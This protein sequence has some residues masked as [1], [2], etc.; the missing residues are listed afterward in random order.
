MYRKHWIA[1]MFA[2]LWA[3]ATPQPSSTSEVTVSAMK[4]VRPVTPQPTSALIAGE[5]LALAYS[6]FR[7]GQHPDRG[8][9]DASPTAAQVEEDLR[10]L[11]DHGVKLIRL[12]DS[13][14][15]SAMV[16]DVIERTKLPI[17]VVLG[18]WLHAE[19][20]AH[21]TCAWLTEPIPQTELDANRKKN[22]EELKR[23]IALANRH[24]T[25]VAA[26]NVGN[27]ALVT[28][29]DHL[30][31][32]EAMVAYIKAVKA[33]I[34]QPV[35]T[36][37]NYVPW[38][39]HGPAL[40]TAADFA[41]VHTYPVWENKPL[42]DSMAYTKQNLAMVH[43]AIPN[44]P[45]AIGEA[46]WPTIATEFGEAANEESQATYVAD[47]LAFGREHNITVFVFEAFDED[48]KGDANPDGAE[49]T[50]GPVRHRPKAE[51]RRR[52]RSPAQKGGV[53]S[54]RR[55]SPPS[56]SDRLRFRKPALLQS[57]DLLFTPSTQP[58]DSD[59]STIRSA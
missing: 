3:C 33:E 45:I 2:P 48:W 18:A 54:G 32:I 8:D 46:G 7:R 39:E 9:G 51:G 19:L 55:P 41:F 10:I 20:S 22:A 47:L 17:R 4:P 24:P 42:A 37:D 36:A 30:V 26:V 1:A 11:A 5:S 31:S 49:K 14:K 53:N 38:T 58:R 16:L 27:E 25:V 50:L 35:S 13:G 15:N 43:A 56:P 52:V 23:T 59:H 44:A 29:N 40:M 28:W 12:Y 6:G 34:S 21:E 57:T